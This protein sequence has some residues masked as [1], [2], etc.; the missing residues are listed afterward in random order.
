MMERGHVNIAMTEDGDTN[1]VDRSKDVTAVEQKTRGSIMSFH[2]IQ[3]KVQLSGGLCNNKTTPRDILFDI[4][5]IMRP[6]LNAILGPTG[7]GK[8]SLLDILASRKDPSGLSGE[9]L[10]DKAPQPPNFKWISGFVVQD[11]V[12]MATLTVRENLRFSAALRLSSSVHQSEKEARV[13]HLIKE[14]GLI[15]V[16]DSRVGSPLR[17]GISG[18][19]RKRTSIGME[20]ITDPS[21]LFL[22]EPTSGLDA[23]TANSVLLLLKRMAN[24]GRTVI[25]SIHQPRYSI[26]KLFDSMTLLDNGKM[27]YHGPATNALDYFAN[28]GYFCEPHNNP[29]DFFLDVINGDSNTTTMKKDLGSGDLD[30][31]ELIGS[32]QGI[33]ENLVE[34]YKN[35]SYYRDM[36]A[37]LDRIIQEKKCISY[38]TSETMTY[39]SSFFHQLRWVLRRTFQNYFLNPEVSVAQ[40]VVNII[41]AL[42]VGIIFFGVKDDQ[43]GLQNRLGV[44]FFITVNMCFSTISAA[45]LFIVD[46]KL[47][48]HEYISG[49]YRVSVYFLSQILSSIMLRIIT[50]VIFCCIA[51]FMIG[52]K[53]TA[54]AFFFFVLTVT[55]VNNTALALVVAISADQT[56]TGIANLFLTIIFIFMMIFSG[57]LVN[58]PNMP[59]W[60]SWLGY[61]S[62]P[63]YGFSALEINE[64]SDL[65]FCDEAVIRNTNRS[66]VGTNSI[67]RIC[68]GEEYLDHMGKDHTTWAMW[69]NTVALIVMMFIFLIIGYIKLRYIRKFT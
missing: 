51:Y 11:D 28:I 33:R 60:L 20:L 23:G 5:G 63:R 1:G 18:G 65:K 21:I 8:S 2:N 45:D 3:Y 19:E 47:F 41:L 16:A 30:F 58:L 9:V 55:L 48:M 26:Y 15:K 68:T 54:E 42:F 24:H 13:N 57:L 37:E 6:G 52:L 53:S 67:S 43:S 38:S 61:L 17:R 4:N 49:Y 46:R 32:R 66:H 39:N 59:N 29:A 12:V 69:E 36:T 62:I 34:E 50:S 25:M 44:L 31:E 7:S 64:L 14:L 56:S 40:I 22:D 10:I 27:V 35:S